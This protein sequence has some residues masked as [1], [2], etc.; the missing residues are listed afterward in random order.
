MC[1][2]QVDRLLLFTHLVSG[3][4]AGHNLVV[5]MSVVA[6]L[7]CGACLMP[8]VPTVW[9]A[10]IVRCHRV[11]LNPQRPEGFLFSD[12]LMRFDQSDQW[13]VFWFRGWFGS[14]TSFSSLVGFDF[15]A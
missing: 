8:L 10:F 4:M 12:S 2:C 5:D 13:Q 11:D 9:L 14:S 3:V 6:L 1:R 15:I 7:S